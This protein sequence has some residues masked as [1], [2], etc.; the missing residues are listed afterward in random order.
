MKFETE[1]LIL[2]K[3][4]IEDAEN[5]YKVAKEKKVARPCGWKEHE[6]IGESKEIIENLFKKNPYAFAVCLKKNNIAIGCIEI[7]LSENSRLEV[8]KDIK[9]KKD[10]ELGCW[11]GKEFWGQGLMYEAMQELIK[12]S[13]ENLG[14][15]KIYC[16][17]TD[18]NI[19]SKRLQEKC[20]FTYFLTEEKRL[21]RIL[22]EIR[23]AH[24]NVLTKESWRKNE[25]C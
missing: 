19:K 3:W 11:I 4:L 1:R 25:N 23:K 24:V 6:S 18:G 20:G 21:Y 5:L 7:I 12:F 17:Y 14:A 16:S 9:S 8:L 22:N 10:L 15:D 2:R 13:F